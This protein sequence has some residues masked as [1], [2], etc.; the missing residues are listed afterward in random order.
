VT[1]DGSPVGLT[2]TEFRILAILASKREW[3][4]TR[5]HILRLL[6]GNEK[7]VIERTVD[8]H[9]ANLRAKLGPAGGCI[10]SVRSVGYSIKV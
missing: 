9:V 4:F 2:S 8:G 7:A 5:E 6:W 10:R 3:V 1:V